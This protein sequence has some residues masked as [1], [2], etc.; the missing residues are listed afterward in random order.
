MTFIEQEKRIETTR[1]KFQIMD[2]DTDL[3]IYMIR[4]NEAGY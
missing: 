2:E 3:D 4:R 1:R